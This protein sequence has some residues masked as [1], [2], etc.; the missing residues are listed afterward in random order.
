[1]IDLDA[2][3]AAAR[4]ATPGEWGHSSYP[5]GTEFIQFGERG[6]NQS[7]RGAHITYYDVVSLGLSE[8]ETRHGKWADAEYISLANPATI[9]ALIA[10]LR[11]AEAALRLVDAQGDEPSPKER[12]AMHAALAATRPKGD[13]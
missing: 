6:P 5:S 13:G 7:Y 11:A 1:M 3:E 10:R 2:L 8:R 12:A 9:L 4:A